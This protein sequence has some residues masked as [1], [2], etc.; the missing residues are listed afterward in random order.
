MRKSMHGPTG[1]CQGFSLGGK[2]RV[3]LFRQLNQES[4]CCAG[5]GVEV[6]EEDGEG[7]TGGTDGGY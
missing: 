2:W 1:T 4:P 7:G 5:A 3:G 6:P